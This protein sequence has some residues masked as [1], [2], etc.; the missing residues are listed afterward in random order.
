MAESYEGFYGGATSALSSDYG[1]L[2]NGYQMNASMLG[3]PG[4]PQSA[5][6]VQ[7]VV[8]AV[9]HGTKVFEVTMLQADVSESIPKQHFEEMRALMKLT[10]V[11]PSVHAPILDAAGF[12]E[13]GW[14]PDGR[15]DNERRLFAA[16]E[17]AQEL[18]PSGN[19][20]IVMHAA[21][22]APGTEWRPGD[23][24]K[25]EDKW[26][27]DSS[28]A[29]NQ[30]TG[31]AAPIKREFKIRPS[32]PELLDRGGTYETDDKGKV[33]R[34]KNGRPKYRFIEGEQGLLDKAED[35]VASINNGEW[36]GKLTEVAQLTKHV[37]EII[38]SAFV[39]LREDYSRAVISRDSK[40]I[41]EV[42]DDGAVKKEL[43]MFNGEQMGQYEHMLKADLFM[44]NAELSFAGAFG[45]AYKYGTPDQ[46]KMLKD[47]SKRYSAGSEA[48]GKPFYVGDGKMDVAT[49]VMAPV[50]KQKLLQDSL[51]DLRA[52]TDR[53]GAPEIFKLGEKFAMEKAAKTFGNLAAKG[54][55]EW[56]EK[57]PILALENMYQ[58]MAFSRAEDM[59]KL[60]EMS[61][62][63]FVEQLVEKG[64]S[65]KQA[66]KLAEDK[67]G[68]TWD[69]GHLNIMRKKGFTE[70][71]I[72]E[73]TK[74]ISGTDKPGGDKSMVKHVHL[75][76]NFGFADTHLVPGMG[77][78]PIKGI[79]EELEKTGRFDEMRKI[80]EAGG[81][82][83]H[84]RK[85]P[86]SMTM[87]AFGSGIY[88][89]KNGP[90]W[91]QAVDTQG[92]Y[93]GGYGN[94]N[95]QTHHSYFG[96]GFTT[97]PVELGGQMAGGQSRFGGAPM[98]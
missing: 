53:G 19:L 30:E 83:Q 97:M 12:G 52:I 1:N 63:N 23:E 3:F 50:Q 41:F 82:V 81:I 60:V 4:S 69:V 16:I 2:N 31:Q 14:T 90:T 85:L 67:L 24:K 35:S 89:M 42:D 20:P 43:D 78:V 21:N 25:G 73:Q 39:H 17:K 88:G 51:R 62:G 84:F 70:K 36:S 71:D 13:R 49:S 15:S 77:N 40:K 75:T 74:I 59:K 54:H 44:D 76:D 34:D 9:K 33:V 57:A 37:D 61:R 87:A 18:D 55:K 91:A 6:Q 66:K 38:G 86:H 22:G 68:V 94:L 11:K 32:H 93:S 29:I 26:V 92:V 5:N 72:I 45:Q 65:E 56:G 27:M 8:N 7:D 98:A 10:G 79:L 48:I 96:A 95:P 58:G 46:K 64:V 80:T 28:T 47:L